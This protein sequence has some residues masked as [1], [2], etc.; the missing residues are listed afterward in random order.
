MFIDTPAVVETVDV[1]AISLAAAS[2]SAPLSPSAQPSDSKPP[3]SKAPE[4]KAL[5]SKSSGSTL[6]G[7]WNGLRTRFPGV[8]P[9]VSYVAEIAG[10]VS[11]DARRQIT[12]DD[13]IAFGLS[14]DTP[15]LFGGDGKG[16]FQVNLSHRSG[17]NLSG[18]TGLNALNTP[19][20][21][22]GRGEVWRLPQFWY[23]ASRGK[24]EIK[25]GRMT[26]GE[27]MASFGCDFMSLYFCSAGPG[28]I[29]P[30]Y[31]HNYPVSL[32]A[33]RVRQDLSGGAYVQT[34]IY[35]I[36][37]HNLDNEDGMDVS[38]DTSHGYTV[39]LEVTLTPKI[40][41]KLAGAWRLGAFYSSV[42]GT[43]VTLNTNHLPR[44]LYGGAPLVHADMTGYYANIA[45]TL[46]LP[47]A[48]GSGG[49]RVFA[50]LTV[51]D[52]RTTAYTSKAAIGL[53]YSGPLKG[54][55]KDELAV[56]FGRIG[57]N[58]RL[59]EV[60]R[61]QALTSPA[62]RVQTAEYSTEINYAY[63]V[64]PGLTLRPNVQYI[65]NPAGMAS[66]GRA[67]VAGMRILADF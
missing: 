63:K 8:R 12:Y 23:K 34:G 56:A 64:R 22:Y 62:V 65:V 25:L 30:A 14:L 37:P 39:P 67:V 24:T 20:A 52:G 58:D 16:V 2:S 10:V 59:S 9:S 43:D 7:D 55:P 42:N 27:D 47:E 57:V 44:A 33:A 3:E 51:I 17:N 36:S 15:N 26:F 66:R 32:W 61:L 4:S 60:Q 48:D 13:Q 50:N 1:R 21:Y 6:F 31:W 28:Q 5:G 54:R 18:D 38:W 53:F 19:T 40:G 35:Q 49:V 46:R 11:G 29:A 41:G 45:Q